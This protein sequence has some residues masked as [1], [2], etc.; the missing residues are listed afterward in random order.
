M[1]PESC[2]RAGLAARSEGRH[3]DAERL[4]GELLAHQPGSAD[5]L[6]LLGESLQAQG[7]RE[8]AADRFEQALR[9]GQAQPA[10]LLRL[11][12]ALEDLGRL[13]PAADAWR[14]ASARMPAEATVAFNLARLLQATGEPGDALQA[15]A[16]AEAQAAADLLP[17]VWQLRAQILEQQELSDDALQCLD[18]ALAL[19]PERPALHHNRAVLLL[20]MGRPHESLTAHEQARLHGLAAPDAHYNL[21]NTL[22]A[23]GRHDEAVAAYREALRLDPLHAL[24]LWDLARLRWRRGERDFSAELDAAASSSPQSALPLALKGRLLLRAGEHAAAA[25]AFS[26]AAGVAPEDAAHSDGLGQA[27]RRMGRTD[28]AL[29][30]HERATALAPGL[31]A[32][33]ISHAAAL[34]EK[35][36]PAAAE[37]AARRALQLTP[38][39]QEAWAMRGLAWRVL[40]DARESTLNDEGE[41]IEVLQVFDLME[42][43]A[44]QE[45]AELADWLLPQ[46][47]DRREPID[48]TLRGGT[49]TLGRLFDLADAPV[50]GLKQRLAEGVDR[51]LTR[52]RQLG[53]RPGH[54]LLDRLTSGWHFSDSWS[55]R[56][57][58]GG[59]HTPHVHPHGWVSACFYVAVPP[60]ADVGPAGWLAL[61]G[62][63]LDVPGVPMHARRLVRPQPGSLV[64]FPSYM[65]HATVPFVDDQVRLTVAF[66]VLPGTLRR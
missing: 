54:P 36:E 26:A 63:D 55:S 16:R 45:L 9:T 7:L 17:Q 64:L 42:A 5:L 61:G 53:P 40:G 51:Y 57:R 30:A 47:F 13:G 59:Y 31:A 10:L 21:G 56:L 44:S 14:S 4:F 3:R 19:A 34:L 62:P 25:Q 11:A 12:P 15:L 1:T 33:H 49:Q 32:T 66:D 50:Q 18:R 22:Q 35:G 60:A 6:C 52:L 39:E 29:Q 58:S 48:Q 27:L 46:H 65:W 8:Q 24:A 20:R 37:Q 38:H 28:E 41:F 23:L 43:R 2:F